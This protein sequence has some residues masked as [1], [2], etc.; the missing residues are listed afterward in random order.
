LEDCPVAGEFSVTG[1]LQEFLARC[2]S[3][4]AGCTSR[5]CSRIVGGEAKQEEVFLAPSR[6]ISIIALSG[7]PNVSAIDAGVE[8]S[9]VGVRRARKSLVTLLLRVIDAGLAFPSLPD[10][11]Q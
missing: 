9:R 2:H 11:Q 10:G 5:G 4:N 6:A 8:P 7:A 3:A 1:D